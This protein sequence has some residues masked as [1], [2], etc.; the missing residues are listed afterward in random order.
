MNACVVAGRMAAARDALE[1]MRAAGFSPSLRC[2]NILLKGYG[3]G[4]QTE[5]MQRTVAE[6]RADGLAPDRVAYN[7]LMNAFV[8]AGQLAQVLTFWLIDAWLM[9]TR[10]VKHC[11]CQLHQSGLTLAVYKAA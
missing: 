6:L 1:S 4:Q 3:Q 10:R 2:Y 8:E 11:L 7:T 5:E 9:S